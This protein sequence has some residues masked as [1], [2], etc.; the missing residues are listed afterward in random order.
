MESESDE[1]E[2]VRRFLSAAPE[3]W[4]DVGSPQDSPQVREMR[5]W[6][7]LYR[8]LSDD[9]PSLVLTSSLMTMI[10]EESDIGGGFLSCSEMSRGGWFGETEDARAA[11]I[12][13]R[14]GQ[15]EAVLVACAFLAQG[16][17][18]Y[19]GDGRPLVDGYRF[20]LPAIASYFA[21]D[22]DVDL[23]DVGI[24]RGWWDSA[25]TGPM[26]IR[27]NALTYALNPRIDNARRREVMGRG[28]GK[29]DVWILGPTGRLLGMDL[30][31]L[32]PDELAVTEETMSELIEDLGQDDP[33]EDP[34]TYEGEQLEPMNLGYLVGAFGDSLLGEGSASSA[35]VATSSLTPSTWLEAWESRSVMDPELWP[36]GPLREAIGSSPW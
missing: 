3:R 6:H 32:S 21:A 18:I 30:S 11:A 36:H 14:D 34:L 33:P 25:G 10:V 26:P 29:V 31:F 20:L 15:L 8:A 27:P 22:S 19:G 13:G 24:P 17:D 35:R 23:A 28:P 9:L 5:Q 7:A 12:L 2:S 1:A 4:L 16:F